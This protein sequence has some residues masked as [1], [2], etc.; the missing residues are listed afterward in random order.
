[1]KDEVEQINAIKK[2]EERINSFYQSFY[3]LRQ[4]A[5]DSRKFWNNKVIVKDHRFKQELNPI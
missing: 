1:M 2:N 3:D 5:H 4:R